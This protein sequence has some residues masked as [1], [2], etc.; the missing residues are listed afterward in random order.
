MESS[1]AVCST[2]RHFLNR[3][4]LLGIASSLPLGRLFAYPGTP[5]IPAS[6]DVPS[7]TNQTFRNR[8]PL[9][10][11]AFYFL[12]QGSVRPAGWLR[13]QLRTQADGLSGH[14]DETW[15]DLGPESGWLGGKGES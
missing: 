4:G 7:Q 8:T 6:V 15:A 1:L 14:L 11:S 10:P 5:R 13:E 3:L 12:P 2:R 9:A